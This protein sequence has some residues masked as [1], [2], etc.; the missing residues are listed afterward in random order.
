MSST[1]NA[2]LVASWPQPA[3]ASIVV[4]TA[5]RVLAR[6]GDTT[7]AS[8]VASIS[9]IFAGLTAM[10]ALEEGT[11]DLDEPAG[12]PGS[13]V[14]H[15]LS[16]ASGWAFDERTTQAEPGTRRIYSNAG[17]EAF[18]EHLEAKSDIAFATYQHEAVIAPLALVSTHLDGS[19]AHGVHT[20]TEDLGA[21]ARELLRPTLIDEA[22]LA[23]GLTPQFASLRGVIP[24]FG[25]HDP[26]PWGLGI[27]LRGA[28]QPHWT[29]PS[30]S[31]ATFGHFGGS[32]TY[33]WVDPERG[34][35]ATAISG[36]EYGP[37]ANEVWPV[38]NELI[39]DRFGS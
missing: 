5:D 12:P 22:T 32:G 30:N 6:V 23:L 35:A 13:T 27:E 36:T 39:L 2:D 20:N 25:S 8:R 15:L 28:K 38:T 31:P 34:L 4:T 3:D 11:I 19:P 10:V 21:L 29:A 18:A 1:D 24:G 37:W 33:L 7:R 26:N 16:H 9:K 17:I 14:R